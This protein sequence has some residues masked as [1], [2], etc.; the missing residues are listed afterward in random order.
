MSK[1]DKKPPR[2]NLSQIQQP[3]PVTSIRYPGTVFREPGS[4]D[5]GA[6]SRQQGSMRLELEARTL[7]LGPRTRVQGSGKVLTVDLLGCFAEL[8]I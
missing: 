7:E 3:A 8:L 6:S 2:A 5:L 4:W 1:D